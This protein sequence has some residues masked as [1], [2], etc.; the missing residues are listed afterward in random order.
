MPDENDANE[1][2]HSLLIER[3]FYYQVSHLLTVVARSVFSLFSSPMNH[4][5]VHCLTQIGSG[6]YGR[7]YTA[8]R[9]DNGETVV[10]KQVSLA[11]LTPEMQ[12][13]TLDEAR[14]MAAGA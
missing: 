6:T 10:V 3:V 2:V 12:L 11:G 4:R 5:S 13:K 14:V 9:V 1:F 7:V 8:K